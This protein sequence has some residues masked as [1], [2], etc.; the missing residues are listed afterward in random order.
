MW[1]RSGLAAIGS[2]ISSPHPDKTFTCYFTPL[3]PP[4]STFLT[5]LLILYSHNFHNELSNETWH[6]VKILR[7]FTVPFTLS[8]EWLST[9]HSQLSLPARRLFS[10]TR[11]AARIISNQPL[12]AKEASPF[13][14]NKYPVIVSYPSMYA[15]KT[16]LNSTRTMNTMLSSS[17][18]ADL[19]YEQLSAWQ[20]LDSIRHAYQNSFQREVIR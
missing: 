3:H 13:I 20:K 4:L 10:S 2:N 12:R 17:V 18:P 14:S 7:M 15:T 1:S 19:D 6:S 16:S 5:V 11:P 8:N 9:N